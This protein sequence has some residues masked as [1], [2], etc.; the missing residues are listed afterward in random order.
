MIFD[1]VLVY[2]SGERDEKQTYENLVLIH[3]FISINLFNL[4]AII[5]KGIIYTHIENPFEA[6][7]HEFELCLYLP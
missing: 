2:I 3:D 7:K 1:K 6:L 4:H 5:C